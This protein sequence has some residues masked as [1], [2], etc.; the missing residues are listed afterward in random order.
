[1]LVTR[2][3][4]RITRGCEPSRASGF[5]EDDLSLFSISPEEGK[6]YYDGGYAYPD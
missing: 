1:M 3:T 4:L 2:I 6:E 5:L